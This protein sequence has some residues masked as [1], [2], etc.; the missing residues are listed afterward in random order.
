LSQQRPDS[1]PANGAG[2]RPLLVVA[3]SDL[4]RVIVDIPEMEAPLVDSGDKAD[5]AI[6]HVQS[7]RDRQFDA[8]VTR[9]AWSLDASNRSLR[10][11]IDIPNDESLLRP[12]MFATVMMRLELRDNA[13][14]LP[15]MAIVRDGQDAYCFVVQSGH[16]VRRPIELGLRSGNEVEIVAGLDDHETVVLAR[17]D[18]LR[19]GQSV[20][21]INADN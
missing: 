13:L 4:V 16:V 3:R 18:S 20:E 21:R 9:T 15:T 19:D 7:L 1:A 14:T 6:V 5:P 2:A 11:V 8:Q 10:T 12:G 17:A